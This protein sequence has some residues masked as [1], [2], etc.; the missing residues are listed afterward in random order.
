[1]KMATNHQ[2]PT[3]T[4][5]TIV[6]NAFTFTWLLKLNL[7]KRNRWSNHKWLSNV[8]LEDEERTCSLHKVMWDGLS[9]F[10]A[11]HSSIWVVQPNP[12]FIWSKIEVH[13]M[14]A[15][16]PKLHLGQC[17]ICITKL[18]SVIHSC[19]MQFAVVH[20]HIVN[21]AGACHFLA[22]LHDMKSC[23][24]IQ[25]LLFNT[26]VH[27][28]IP[29]CLLVDV[30]HVVSLSTK[31]ATLSG[32]SLFIGFTLVLHIWQH[33]AQWLKF[34]SRSH[35]GILDTLDACSFRSCVNWVKFALHCPKIPLVGIL[36][37][38]SLWRMS[39]EI[40]QQSLQFGKK[41]LH[42]MAAYM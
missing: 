16:L 17:M 8:G 15:I 21:Y 38:A 11:G 29:A 33:C 22:C 9:E 13:G 19:C 34:Q 31:K 20:E 1:M 12:I 18:C 30:V 25:G 14:S 26:G 41:N 27:T 37:R 6:L 2:L 39:T 42:K 28:S 24:N 23:N 36:V 35:I 7:N 5:D 3:T 32:F 10:I 40:H 4:H